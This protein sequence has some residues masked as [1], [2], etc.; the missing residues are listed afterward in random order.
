MA[1]LRDRFSW[2]DGV[3]VPDVWD[4]VERRGP[5]P[6]MTF[7]TPPSRRIG[8]IAVALVVL[9]VAG[10]LVARAFRP[11][12]VPASP[13]DE[14]TIVFTAT[15]SDDVTVAVMGSSG[16]KWV[17]PTGMV[18]QIWLTE[19]EISPDGGWVTAGTILRERTDVSSAV[20]LVPSGGGTLR[21]PPG[22]NFIRATQFVEVGSPSWSPHGRRIAFDAVDDGVWLGLAFAPT[23]RA[24]VRS[25]VHVVEA[26]DARFGPGFVSAGEPTWSPVDPAIAVSVAI[27]RPLPTPIRRRSGSCPPRK[28]ALSGG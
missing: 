19:P 14:G 1:E 10:Y 4:R 28:A 12:A 20:V 13:I 27:D 9:L 3:A 26:E 8:A 2:L 18:G 5:Q 15:A 21:V 23:K 6:P 11:E 7:P 25:L 16:V 24:A 17:V 22:P